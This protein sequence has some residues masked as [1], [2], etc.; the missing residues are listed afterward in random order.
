M[1]E[2]EEVQRLL[3]EI[4]FSKLTTDEIDKVTNPALRTALHDLRNIGDEVMEKE[5]TSHGSHTDHLKGSIFERPIGEEIINPAVVN[6][7]IINPGG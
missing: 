1:P 7:E 5:H 4:D 3:G 2:P 6:P